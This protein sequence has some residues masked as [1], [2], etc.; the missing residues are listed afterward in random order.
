MPGNG[1]TSSGSDVTI[2]A[3]TSSPKS[4]ASKESSKPKEA[5][6]PEGILVGKI[7]NLV[8]VDSDNIGVCFDLFSV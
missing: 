3:S 1:E 7:N 4:T 6:N 2:Q 5:K 8:T